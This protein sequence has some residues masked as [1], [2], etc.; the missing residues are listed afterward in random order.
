MKPFFNFLWLLIFFS[1]FQGEA[2]NYIIVYEGFEDKAYQI[3]DKKGQLIA[4]I[5]EGWKPQNSR[6][7]IGVFEEGICVLAQKIDGKF[8]YRLLDTLG[9]MVETE[10]PMDYIGKKQEGLINVKKE[11]KSGYINSRGE[12][13]I[14][15][16][17]EAAYEFREGVARVKVN[18][19]F[20]VIDKSGNFM[21]E[22]EFREVANMYEGLIFATKDRKVFAFYDANG[23]MVI[24]ETSD[25]LNPNCYGC[26]RVFR[27]G[28]FRVRVDEAGK[29]Y[30]YLNKEGA[31]AI[32]PKFEAAQDF[33]NGL[34]LVQ[35]GGLFGYID[36]AGNYEIPPSFQH[37]QLFFGGSTWVRK[38]KDAPYGLIDKTGDYIIDPHYKYIP[39]RRYDYWLAY[40][41][42][43][44]ASAENAPVV[45]GYYNK[46]SLPDRVLYDDSGREVLRIENCSYL[47]SIDDY[48]FKVEWVTPR[49]SAA[50]SIINLNGEI[51]WQTD[52]D[53]FKCLGVNVIGFF[54]KKDIT[55]MDIRR[56]GGRRGDA[57][58]VPVFASELWAFKQLKTLLLTSYYIP[59]LPE[60]IGTLKAL[61][62]LDLSYC[63]LENIPKAIFN[64]RHLKKL[65]LDYNQNL[66]EL[67]KGFLKKMQHLE[68]LSI[69]RCGFSPEQVYKIRKKMKNTRV[70]YK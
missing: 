52:P 14:P 62:S 15:L 22:P 56:T 60:E 9:N 7:N 19:H 42:V 39:Y 67:P 5:P 46:K 51:L 40:E 55:Y 4:A 11:N 58:N 12:V 61:E 64:L 17:F 66:K 33:E 10:I 25:Y 50:Y 3:I 38:T 2:Q 13:V 1:P 31:L 21:L 23:E 29:L 28:L 27:D 26:G 32:R 34:A 37:A 53:N 54:D 24:P 59:N 20:G 44:E 16:Q 35:E 8:H 63:A 57:D 45:I 36:T 65:N 70:I 18:Q 43:Q 48:F 49:N 41:P 69:A 68:E 47:R 6:H 30:G